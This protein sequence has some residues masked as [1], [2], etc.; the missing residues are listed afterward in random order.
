MRRFDIFGYKPEQDIQQTVEFPVILDTERLTWRHC[1]V[2]KAGYCCI[3]K[4]LL[5]LEPMSVYTVYVL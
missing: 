4:V 1:N 5:D 2:K 3:L